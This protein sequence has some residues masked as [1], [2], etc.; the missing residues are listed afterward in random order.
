MHQS[1]HLRERLAN[2]STA[3]DGRGG[4]EASGEDARGGEKREEWRRWQT[5]FDRVDAE[6]GIL[7]ALQ[8]RGTRAVSLASACCRPLGGG[9]GACFSFCLL[10]SFPNPGAAGWLVRGAG[11]VAEPKLLPPSPSLHGERACRA[12]PRVLHGRGEKK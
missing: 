4:R 9:N 5:V 8:V 12:V 2:V 10:V 1:R 6:E 3:P 7:A 11:C